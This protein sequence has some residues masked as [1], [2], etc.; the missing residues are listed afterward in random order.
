M[1]AYSSVEHMGILAVGAALGGLGIWAA[2]FHVWTN[3]LTKGA[4]FLSA[5][6]IRRAAG[7]RRRQTKCPGMAWCAPRFG[8]AVRRRPVC[9]H[10]LSAVRPVLQR[11]AGRARRVRAPAHG[12]TAVVFLGSLLFAFFGL[13]RLVFAIVDGRPRAAA[14][15]DGRPFPRNGGRD[16]AA[17]GVSRIFRLARPGHAAV[18]ERSLDGGRQSCFRAMNTPREFLWL[19]NGASVPWADVPE[20][21]GGG[22]CAPPPPPNWSAAA[23]SAPGSAC[24]K[25]PARGW[26]PSLPSTRTTRW[27]WA[28]ACRWPKA[29]RRSPCGSRR[30]ICSSAK[31][32]SS[33]D[34][35]PK[36]IRG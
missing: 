26:W 20:W 29:I 35:C 14:R 17:A 15:A 12:L 5:G 31:S 28:A 1:L 22:I 30:R 3:S 7:A 11:T 9:H 32:G 24:R 34:L 36:A 2:L 4:L 27:P 19:S 18:A 33:T 25:P 8:A 10:R 6:N 16:S 13:T 23:G 21:P